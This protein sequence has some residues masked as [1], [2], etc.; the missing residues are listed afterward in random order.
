M[1]ELHNLYDS[2]NTSREILSRRLR[3]AG[4]VARVGEMRNAH[5]ILVGKF[6]V[7]DHSEDLGVVAKD[8]IRMDLRE[9]GWEG[10]V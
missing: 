5:N 7:R 10:V 6:K 2:R 1:E 3:W 8:Y 4:H 9:R